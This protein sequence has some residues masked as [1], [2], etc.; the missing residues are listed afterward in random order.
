MDQVKAFRDHHRKLNRLAERQATPKK[1]RAYAEFL[2]HIEG[3]P[4]CKAKFEARQRVVLA[5]KVEASREQAKD[6]LD[7]VL[8]RCGVTR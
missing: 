4:S 1:R 2:L 7:E 8:M 6:L 5:E 3:C